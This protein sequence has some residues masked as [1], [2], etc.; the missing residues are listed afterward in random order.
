MESHRSLTRNPFVSVAALEQ[1]NYCRHDGSRLVRVGTD[2]AP[3]HLTTFVHDSV[4]ALALNPHF[5]CVG[6]KSALRR[7]SYGFGL[8][9]ELG[10]ATSV[11]GLAHDLC[12]FVQ[13]AATLNGEFSTFIASFTGPAIASEES[14]EALLW[15]TLQ[16]LHDLDAPHYAWANGVSADPADTHF[17]FSFAEE[18]L[19]VVGLHAASSRLTRRCAWPTLVFNPRQQFEHLKATGR[20]ERFQ[21][22]IRN[23]ERNLQG[24]INPMLA[25]FGERSE[26]AQYSGRQ[27]GPQWRCPFH[28]QRLATGSKG[29][30]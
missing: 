8:Y 12:C 26:A 9:C 14:F 18:A 27:V 10:S 22:V 1:S 16:Q 25:D 6:A 29:T 4:L 2:A 11:A 3:S 15:T 28:A 20:Y 5:P 7:H 23:A 30:S 21:Q 24:D 17:S 19:F 13:E